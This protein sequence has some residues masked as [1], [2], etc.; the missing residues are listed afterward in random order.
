[1]VCT[2]TPTMCVECVCL[3]LNSNMILCPR[4]NV[5]TAHFCFSIDSVCSKAVFKMCFAFCLNTGVHPFPGFGVKVD[6]SQCL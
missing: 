3:L 4:I 2:P 5:L 6:S 1:M